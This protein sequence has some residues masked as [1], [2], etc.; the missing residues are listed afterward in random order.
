MKEHNITHG[1]ITTDFESLVQEIRE[2][3]IKRGNLPHAPI[4]KQLSILEGLTTFPLGR[5][6]L[7]HKGANGFWTDYMIFH[8]KNGKIS[9]LNSEGQPF[10]ELENYFLNRCPIVVAHQERFQIFQKLIQNKIQDG[11]VFA[12]IPCGLMRDLITLDYS[13]IKNFTLIGIDIDEES[14]YLSKKLAL[15]KNIKNIKLIKKNAWDINFYESLDLIT[16]SG[17]N[18]YESDKNKVINL[19]KIFLDSLKP[20]GVLITSILTYPPGEV[21]K[22]DWDLRGIDP[23]DL[24]I[25]QIIHKDILNVKWRNFCSLNE[26]KENFE[27]AG[28]SDVRVFP[29]K[30]KIF[31]TILAKK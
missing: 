11:V 1:S 10:S 5:F 19:Y 24:I 6:V 3:I 18:V 14:L 26:I 21:R 13:S 2:K 12:S 15:E 23:E 27:K 25:D 4:E 17:L 22:T 7:E 31:P 9:G 8:P 29:D 20:G 28:F 30:H 16:S